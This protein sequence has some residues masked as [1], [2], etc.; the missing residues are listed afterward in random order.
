MKQLQW[1]SA[2]LIPEDKKSNNKFKLPHVR[3]FLQAPEL[4]LAQAKAAIKHM[5]NLVK[6]M[7]ISSRSFLVKHSPLHEEA[8]AKFRE[9]QKELRVEVLEFLSN[10]NRQR[11]SSSQTADILNQ[12]SATNEI[13]LVANRLEMAL[14]RLSQKGNPRFEREVEEL[15]EYFRKTVKYFSKSCNAFVNGSLADSQRIAEKI[16]SHKGFEKRFKRKYIEKI[17]EGGVS[18]SPELDQLNLEVLEVLRSINS[19]SLRICGILIEDE[20]KVPA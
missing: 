20:E 18:E 14:E 12:M 15:E 11:L 17:H 9:E 16:L 3:N 13:E 6:A 10:L 19:A 7:M 1:L 2:K 8:I 4:A 5:K